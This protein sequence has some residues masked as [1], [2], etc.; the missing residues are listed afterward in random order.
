MS[1]KKYLETTIGELRKRYGSDFA[2]GCGDNEK[3]MDVLRKLP[4]LRRVIR[5]H[6]ARRFEHVSKCKNMLLS[7]SAVFL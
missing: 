2:K 1:D 7:H 5:E 3:I 6:E 4:L